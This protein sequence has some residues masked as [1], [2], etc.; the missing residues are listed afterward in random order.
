MF[1][2]DAIKFAPFEAII[3]LH[4][5]SGQD[6]FYMYGLGKE[7]VDFYHAVCAFAKTFIPPWI[8]A[9]IEGC[10]TDEHGFILATAHDHA[11]DATLYS[12]GLAKR[13]YTF[14]TP[15][16]LDCTCRVR[17]MVQLVL[18]SVNMLSALRWIDNHPLET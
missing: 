2:K 15:G 8:N 18:Q 17:M 14:E 6:Q 5:D 12:Q 4:E 16:L 3:T 1:Y 10:V 7:N 13:A 9:E 11:F